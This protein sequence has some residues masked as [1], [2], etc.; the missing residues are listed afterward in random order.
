MHAILYFTTRHTLEHYLNHHT[1]STEINFVRLFLDF[2]T[3][4][5]V[6]VCLEKGQ[7]WAQGVVYLFT[8]RKRPGIPVQP[9]W[10]WEDP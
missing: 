2:V 3:S 4:L 9:Q 6:F 10:R 1:L 8:V 5:F 7:R